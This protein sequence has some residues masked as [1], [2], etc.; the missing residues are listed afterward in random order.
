MKLRATLLAG[1]VLL[2]GCDLKPAAEPVNPVL[3]GLSN[4]FGF[5][6]LR[7][8]VKRFT[9]TQTD[10]AGKV[11]AYVEGE[12]DAEG[13]LAALRT[14]QP[15]MNLDLDL[16]RNGQTLVEQSDR[17]ALFQLT[18]HCQLAKT[19]DG[20]LSYRSNDKYAIAEVV[21]RDKPTPLASYRYDDDGF[22]V[23]MTF[24]SPENG[25]VTKVEMRNDAPAQKR[26]DATV[27]V[28]ENDEQ[29]SVTRTSCQYDQHFNPRLCQVLVSNGKGA[30]QTVTTLTHTTKI[31][32]Y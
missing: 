9:Q 18:D 27:V 19:T 20:R 21:Y 24:V 5:D 17:Q 32:Y 29:V 22:P 23:S 31:E 12:F 16:V 28:T 6:A 25:K 7:G 3:A 1:S 11:T 14:Y 10:D 2:A 30:A 26:L 13:C 8:K 4:I 15:S